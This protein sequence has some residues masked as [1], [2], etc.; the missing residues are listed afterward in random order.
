[1]SKTYSCEKPAKAANLSL[2]HWFFKTQ[3][4]R[5]Y[6]YNPT[7]KLYS[8]AVVRALREGG[9]NINSLRKHRLYDGCEC[10]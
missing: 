6:M 2:K 10:Q 1:M 7:Y 5:F 8:I 9:Y 3:T 4:N